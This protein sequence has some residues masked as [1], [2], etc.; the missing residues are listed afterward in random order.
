MKRRYLGQPMLDTQAVED[1]V[2]YLKTLKQ[3]ESTMAEPGFYDDLKE[4]QPTINH[5]QT[6]MWQ[7]GDLMHQWEELQ[8]KAD[9]EL[10][11]E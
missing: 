1:L 10:A 8:L 2:A 6:L 11:G 7:I 3:L 5:Y 4:S 9:V